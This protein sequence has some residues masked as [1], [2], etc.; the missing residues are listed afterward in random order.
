MKNRDQMVTDVATAAH[1]DWRQ[2]YRAANG[3]KPR[4]KKTKDQTFIDRGVTEVDIASLAYTELPSDWQGENKLGAEC[5][6]DCVVAVLGQS[7]ALDA[8]FIEEASAT[9]HDEWLKRNGSWA[10]ESQKLP[11][12]QLTEDEKEKDRFF[13]RQAIAASNS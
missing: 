9:Q 1:E 13:V 2:Q 5:A 3:D 10:P 8:G 4:I 7:R 12:A 11:Y 6:V